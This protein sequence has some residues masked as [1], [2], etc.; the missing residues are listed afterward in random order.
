VVHIQRGIRP[1][2]IARRGP[3]D[4]DRDALAGELDRLA[5]FYDAVCDVMVAEAVHQNVLG[6]NER[7]GAVLAA[8]DRQGIPP[9]M[10]FVRTPRSGTSYTQRV[11]VLLGRDQAPVAWSAIPMDPRGAV[12]PRLN[13]WIGRLV[14]DPARVRVAA[15]VTTGNAG[16]EVSVA[17]PQIG[18]TPLALVVASQTPAGDRSELEQ[19]IV[20]RAAA[21]A[22]AGPD[23]TIA[24]LPRPPAGSGPEILGLGAL[25]ALLRRIYVLVTQS[26]PATAADLS[27]P[28]DAADTGLDDAQLRG[29]ADA[30]ATAFGEALDKIEH[31]SAANAAAMRAALATAAAFGVRAAL[32]AMPVDGDSEIV[33]LAA[34]KQDA[35]AAMRTAARA[36][37]ALR[38]AAPGA[39][40]RARVA[41]Q[42][43]RIRALVGQDFPVLPLVTAGN[44]TALR[45]A[46]A[47]RD[48]L[49]AGDSLAPSAWLSRMAL[50][51]PDVD[52]L[53]SV[54]GAAELVGGRVAASDLIVAQLPHHGGDRWLALRFG[55]GGPAQAELAIVAATD[56]AVDFDRPIAGLFCDGW[57]E[58]IPAREE[59]TGIAFH[60]DAP[61]ARPPQTVLLAVPPQAVNP[62]WSVDAIVDT[63][64]EAHDLARI[65]AV[66]TR[67][68]AWLGT[69]LPALYLPESL[70]KDVPAINLEDLVIKYDA[71]NAA[72]ASI[73]GKG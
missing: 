56:G 69:V 28:H 10:D 8:L 14:G 63:V 15:T 41:Q 24:L 48:E 61:G 43:A 12:D 57:A 58:T 31:A 45:T 13:A 34:R 38:D 19:R 49:L 35:T 17:L 30:L 42:T 55:D 29:R 9:R 36:E 18:L 37:R 60:H 5:D 59:T 66:D 65:R 2:S 23:A 71:V 20:A 53:A 70:A 73:L 7:A 22:N 1:R 33:S 46:A 51:R 62:A 21:Q 6:N 72:T 44:K 27:L 40:P 50:V 52:R 67:H 32:P 47:A 39:T 4:A 54:R 16:H 68:L 3:A 26:R 25:V 64:V 11:L